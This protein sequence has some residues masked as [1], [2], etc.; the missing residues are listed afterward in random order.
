[1]SSAWY[2]QL[3]RLRFAQAEINTRK[4][5]ETRQIEARKRRL[6][7]CKKMRAEELLTKAFYQAELALALRERRIMKANEVYLT[8]MAETLYLN[9]IGRNALISTRIGSN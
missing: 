1:M 4:A 6:A 8:C 2:K 9:F 3:R 7:V 5:A